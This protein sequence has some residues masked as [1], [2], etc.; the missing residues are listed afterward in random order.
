MKIAALLFTVLVLIFTSNLKSQDFKEDSRTQV[1]KEDSNNKY[2][3]EEITNLDLLQALEFAGIKVN[4]FNIGT[5]DKKYKFE[6]MVD[7]YK[8]GSIVNSDTI[9]SYNNEYV[10]YPKQD[11]NYYI[12]Y[13]DQI[14]VISKIEDTVLTMQ[15]STYSMGFRHK[16]N[17]SKASEETYY[18]FRTY[19]DTKWKL[20]KKVPLFIYASSWEDKDSKYQTFCGVVSLSE[21]DSRTIQ[22]LDSSPH[23]YIVNYK[24]SELE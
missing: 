14:K 19:N 2:E 13:F 16:I 12:N 23:Y 8:Q 4:K 21:G 9:L 11:T 6:V 17:Y 22:L 20:N 1:Q 24:I 15:F 5:F 10:F 3:S 18:R 7:E